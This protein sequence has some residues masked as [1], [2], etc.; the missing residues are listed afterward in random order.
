MKIKFNSS[1][2][3]YP[4]FFLPFP[5]LCFGVFHKDEG[6]K[7][8]DSNKPALKSEI[9]EVSATVKKEN[10][11]DKMD[12]MEKE[13]K[14]GDGYSALSNIDAEKSNTDKTSSGYTDAEKRRIDS[15]ESV[16]KALAGGSSQTY[17][18]GSFTKPTSAYSGMSENDRKLTETLNKLKHPDSYPRAEDGRSFKRTASQENEKPKEPLD[19]FRQQMAVMDSMGKMNDPAYKEEQ[20]RLLR[21]KQA[22]EFRKNQP[23]LKVV[24]VNDNSGFFNTIQ[25]DREKTFIK[26]IIDENLTGYLGSRIQIRLLDDIT[27]GNNVIKKGTYLYGEISGF[28]EQ[29]VNIGIRYILNGDKI[30]PVKLEIY[31]MDGLPGLYVPAS[32]FREFSKDLGVTMAQGQMLSSSGQESFSQ[33]AIDKIFTSSTNVLANMIRKNKAKIKYDTFIYLIDPQELSKEQ[34]SY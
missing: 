1:K 29:R 28:S 2:Y 25:V 7:Q 30:L 11:T 4:L 34:K 8:Q 16:K 18:K 10:I 3:I 27:A 31:D 21:Q 6:L 20:Q 5:L 22:E 19:L 33:S 12:A 17:Q 23:L 32:V 9:G 26:A 14:Q 24:K 13:K 15:I